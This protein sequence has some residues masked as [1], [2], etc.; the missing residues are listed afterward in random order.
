MAYLDHINSDQVLS[1]T[2]PPTVDASL[3]SLISVIPGIDV[4]SISLGSVFGDLLSIKLKF[5]F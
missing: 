1:F 4:N 2:V 3:G 5:H